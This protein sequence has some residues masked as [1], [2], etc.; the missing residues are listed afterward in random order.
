MRT[1]TAADRRLL[2]EK[3]VPAAASRDGTP[4][5]TGRRFRPL[6]WKATMARPSARAAREA[7]SLRDQCALR[8]VAC[9]SLPLRVK[10][11]EERD[12]SGRFRRA[13]VLPVRRHV[14]AALD[15]LPDQLILRQP[16]GDSVERG[17]ALPAGLVE[18]M[19]VPAL[20][21]LQDERTVPLQRGAA[22]EVF[23]RNRLAAPCVH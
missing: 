8:S 3:L 20:L 6:R 13:K 23:L 21:H 11:L 4:R 15:D 2:E 16:D 12:E 17:A 5:R 9:G 7:Q 14:A 18:R 10:R 22:L 1:P 19:A